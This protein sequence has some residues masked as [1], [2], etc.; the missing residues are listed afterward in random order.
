MGRDQNHHSDHELQTLFQNILTEIIRIFP[1]FFFSSMLPFFGKLKQ[2]WR[3]F[4]LVRKK[5]N[6]QNLLKKWE[7]CFALVYC[8]R[9]GFFGWNP[10][11]VAMAAGVCGSRHHGIWNLFCLFQKRGRK[12]IQA[13]LCRQS[14]L[15]V[16][17]PESAFTDA[18]CARC[19][20]GFWYDSDWSPKETNGF[21]RRL[22][23]S[24]SCAPNTKGIYS[25]SSFNEKMFVVY[26]IALAL[27]HGSQA[28]CAISSSWWGNTRSTP[29]V[30][31]SN[32]NPKISCSIALHSKCHPGRPG[33]DVPK[34]RNPTPVP[35]LCTAF[36]STKSR[37]SSFSTSSARVLVP[38]LQC[39]KIDMTKFSV[40]IG[41]LPTSSRQ[42]NRASYLF[43]KSSLQYDE[44]GF[45][46]EEYSL[47]PEEWQ[48][49]QT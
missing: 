41:I 14:S 19:Q 43:S 46:S 47:L 27:C 37:K 1:A 28:D 31:I 48:K 34:N 8:L 13:D 11:I 7:T 12:C 18:V 15:G 24:R 3:Y 5:R 23:A 4:S 22:L 32:G 36:Q 29:P 40:W 25:F 21:S 6:T 10:W 16:A 2:K 44:Q 35:L 49:C 9:R 30:W 45:A 20:G 26:E 17:I 39:R 38:C 42:K 33:R